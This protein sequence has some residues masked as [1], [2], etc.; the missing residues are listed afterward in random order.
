[1]TVFTEKVIG[2]PA[3]WQGVDNSFNNKSYATFK[4]VSV[5]YLIFNDTVKMEPFARTDEV[6]FEA[7]AR[8]HSIENNYLAVINAQIYDI[9]AR[10]LIDYAIGDDPVTPAGIEPEGYTVFG[11]KVIAGRAAPLNFFI[12]NSPLA[13]PRYKFG[14]GPAPTNVSG[15]IG[16]AGPLIINKL[17]YGLTNQYKKGATVGRKT[18][19]PTPE[20]TK[21]LVQRSNATFESFSN[22]S[23][24]PK[25]GITAIAHHSNKQKLGI[26]VHPDR[27]GKMPI[28]QFRDKLINAGFDNAI[29]LDGSNSS[30]L[31]VEGVF[32]ARQAASKNK[33]NV[34]G[35]GFKY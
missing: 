12:A 2:G 8:V 19:Q 4:D 29:F 13:I 14:F 3:F 15:A 7:T 32:Y 26:F 22:H 6:M 24:A 27:S 9:N 23:S 11:N 1:M 31:M 17:R 25:T 16:G 28:T 34:V 33:T 30:M 21:N 20:N 10:G 18:G 5:Y 35:I